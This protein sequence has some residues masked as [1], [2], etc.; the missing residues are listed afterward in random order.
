[1]LARRIGTEAAITVAL[2]VI[3]AGLLLRVVPA[4]AALFTGTA[5]AAAGMATGNVLV[6][7]VIKRVFPVAW[8][9][10]PGCR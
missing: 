5:L 7:A 2:V 3:T 10:S 8:D 6:P 1:M 9:R 4:Q